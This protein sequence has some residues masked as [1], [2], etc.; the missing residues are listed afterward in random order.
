MEEGRGGSETP[1]RSGLVVRWGRNSF[2]GARA[3]PG[4]AGQALP[5][6]SWSHGL[7]PGGLFLGPLAE[8]ISGQCSTICW[9][10]L[11]WADSC[12]PVQLLVPLCLALDVATRVLASLLGGLGKQIQ[13]SWAESGWGSAGVSPAPLPLLSVLPAS[14]LKSMSTLLFV[15]HISLMDLF[16][17]ICIRNTMLPL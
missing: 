1:R 11:S 4:I 2:P 13:N 5:P 12:E 3:M 9:G 6:M 15:V 8:A 16:A 7:G 14:T 17:L 10:R